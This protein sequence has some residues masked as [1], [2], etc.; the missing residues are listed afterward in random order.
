MTT[1][2]TAP[3]WRKMSRAEV[4]RGLN[5]SERRANRAKPTPYENRET[6]LLCKVAR[7]YTSYPGPQ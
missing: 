7:G 5:N 3:D 1:D 4:D 2:L 6:A